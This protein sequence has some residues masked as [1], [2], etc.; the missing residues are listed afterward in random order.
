[1][2]LTL[3]TRSTCGR[4]RHFTL[5][6]SNPHLLSW[7]RV[8]HARQ[9]TLMMQNAFSLKLK[10]CEVESMINLTLAGAVERGHGRRVRAVDR[11]DGGGKGNAGQIK[12][13]GD[14]DCDAT[15]GRCVQ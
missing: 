5:L 10:S 4:A 2:A 3:L 14:E 12:A 6:I 13:R 9:V 7:G 8:K 15:S 1:M 11:D